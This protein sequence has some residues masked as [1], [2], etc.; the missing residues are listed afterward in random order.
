MIK[1]L[2]RAAA[3]LRRSLKTSLIIVLSL[4]SLVGHGAFAATPGPA[5]REKDVI[6][7]ERILSKLRDLEE[8][9]KS[10]N[11]RKPARRKISEE[12]FA[13]AA[14]LGAGDLK[15]ELTTALFLYDETLREELNPSGTRPDCVDELSEAYARLCRENP[16]GTLSD[17]LRAKARLHTRLAAAIINEHRD[18]RDGATAAALEEMRSARRDDVRLG[19]QALNALKSLES[20]IY[21]YSSLAEF[22]ERGKLARVPFERLSRDVSEMLRRVD[23][24]L[25][26]LPRSPLFY[27]I[28]H[29]RNA[30]ADGIFWWQKTHG[31]GELVVNVNS[32]KEPYGTKGPGMESVAAVNYTVAINWHKAVRHTRE[33]ARLVEALKAN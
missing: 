16:S 5:L 2:A 17:Y 20:E 22:E 6:R 24:I 11:S 32:F 4:S 23:S 31:L 21:D 29:A 26:S 33:A 3:P 25:G 7:A 18:R 8:Q 9:L 27:P 30:Y 1:S 19:A 12:L 28:Y 10:V 15:T 14:S 13:Q